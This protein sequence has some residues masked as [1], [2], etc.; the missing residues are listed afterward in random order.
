MPKRKSLPS[1]EVRGLPVHV[2][3]ALDEW[4]ELVKFRERIAREAYDF[5][6]DKTQG[7][8]DRIRDRLVISANGLVQVGG[9][10]V[11]VDLQYIEAN[12]LYVA[13]EIL[14]DLAMMDVK[15]ATYKFPPT[16]CAECGAEIK[17][18]KRRKK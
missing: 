14:K 12:A 9:F 8:L 7:V 6:D 13:T 1:P 15:V 18:R 4:K 3:K 2:R 17:P 16:F 5:Q 10:R 11:K